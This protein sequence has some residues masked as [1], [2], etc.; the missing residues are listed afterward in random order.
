[1]GGAEGVGEDTRTSA[2]VESR[3]ASAEGKPSTDP[4]AAALSGMVNVIFLYNFDFTNLNPRTANE[5][6]YRWRNLFHKGL[7]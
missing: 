1:M 7:V 5:P 6:C 4:A 3:K 2:P